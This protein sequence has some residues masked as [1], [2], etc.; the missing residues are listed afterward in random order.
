L[1][2]AVTS[3][4]F[5]F[6][7]LSMSRFS[8]REG[9]RLLLAVNLVS[10]AAVLLTLVVNLRRGYPLAA[11]AAAAL[12]AGALHMLWVRSG[13]PGGVSEAERRAEEELATPT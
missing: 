5:M 9:R 6:G 7:L 3:V 2:A 10:L 12:V 8:H 11:L 13:R 4:S 1:P